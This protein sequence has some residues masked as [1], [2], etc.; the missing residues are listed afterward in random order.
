MNA[1]IISTLLMIVGS[2]TAL[3]NIIV[4]VVKNITWDNTAHQSG[5][6]DRCGGTDVCFWRGLC[7]DP[8]DRYRMVHGSSSH[9]GWIDV[10]LCRNVWIRQV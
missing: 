10:C 3:T 8:C 7:L 2:I 6:V 4:Q 1:E 5:G 9:R